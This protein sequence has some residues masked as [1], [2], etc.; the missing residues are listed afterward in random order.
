MEIESRIFAA[1][2]IAFFSAAAAIA[3]QVHAQIGTAN[4]PFKQPL[5]S[6]SPESSGYFDLPIQR[7]KKSVP[8]LGGIRFD[9]R[10]DDLPGILAGVDR[11]IAEELPRLPDLISREEVFTFQ[12]SS[13]TDGPGGVASNEPSNREFKYLIHSH[14][15]AN[16]S[17]IIEESRVNAKGELIRDEAGFTGLHATGFANQWLFFSRANQPEFRFRYLGQQQKDGRKTF[18]VAFAQD[19]RKVADPAYFMSDGKT[20]PFYYQGVF[21]VDQTTFGIVALH[22]DLSAPV[23]QVHLFGLTTDLKFRSVPIRGYDAVFWLPSEVDISS[24]QGRGPSEE[25]HRYSD[26]HLFHA[27]AKIVTEPQPSN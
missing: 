4:N 3:P 1:F 5:Q 9:P 10:Q 15:A 21:W 19:P 24:D 13:N 17:T 12:G 8:G 26:Y 23:P 20:A 22:T 18:V 27:S 7:L 2:A 16:G 6:P 11:K 25:S 14:R